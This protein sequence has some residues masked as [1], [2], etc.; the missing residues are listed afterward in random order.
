[1]LFDWTYEKIEYFITASEYTE[2]HKKLAKFIV[3][4]LDKDDNLIDVGCGLG[5]IDL[6]IADKVKTITA[7]DE[8]AKVIEAFLNDVR[9][10]GIT[11]IFPKIK[12]FNDIKEN[13]WDTLLLSFFGEPDEKMKALIGSVPKRT[14]L[15]THGED[16]EPLNSKVHPL[17]KTV[18]VSELES[19]FIE[20]NYKYTK[21]NVVID[22]GQPLKSM[23]DAIE[24]LNSYALQRNEREKKERLDVMLARVVET[25]DSR[26]PFFLPKERHISILV[27]E[28]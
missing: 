28:K 4:Y 15:I 3:P 17:V 22:F 19:Y 1:M 11:N 14:I 16:N 18:F 6:E 20:M 24:F 5:R 27:V 9:E 12:D 25:G 26:F 10:R 2:F 13:Q 8:N 21:Q 7:I 23:D